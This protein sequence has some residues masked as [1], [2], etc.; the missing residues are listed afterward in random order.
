MLCACLV[1]HRPFFA[2]PRPFLATLCPF[3]AMLHPFLGMLCVFFATLCLCLAMLCLF[4][5]TL[6]LVLTRHAPSVASLCRFA[7][8]VRPAELADG[9]RLRHHS[10]PHI[11]GLLSVHVSVSGQSS[12]E[13]HTVIVP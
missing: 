12:S 3:P 10:L 2:M 8:I 1:I 4:L 5:A 9:F 11:P 13:P 7:V 6:R